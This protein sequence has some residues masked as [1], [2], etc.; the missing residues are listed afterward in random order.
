MFKVIL[1]AWVGKEHV[2]SKTGA[3]YGQSTNCGQQ[4]AGQSLCS[5]S[6]L[7]RL[8]YVS[9]DV[10]MGAIPRGNGTIK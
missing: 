3:N 5:S 1:T 2:R 7:D 9:E 4:R 10:V 8:G 6:A